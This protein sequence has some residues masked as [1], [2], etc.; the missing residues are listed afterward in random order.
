MQHTPTAEQ[1]AAAVEDGREIVQLADKKL[2]NVPDDPK[3][4][5]D[6]F[7]QRAEE[8]LREVGGVMEGDVLHVMG[9]QQLAVAISAFGRNAGATLVESVTPRESKDIPQSDGSVKK[10]LV[11]T[12]RGFRKVHNY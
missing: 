9:Q 3:L 5:R 8:I 2:L 12:F 7:A 11:F 6:W 1:L 4:S 10:E